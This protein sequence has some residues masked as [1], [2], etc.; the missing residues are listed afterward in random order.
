MS[1]LHLWRS[2][3]PSRTIRWKTNDTMRFMLLISYG[4]CFQGFLFSPQSFRKWSNVFFDICSKW[5]ER[6]QNH[7]WDIYKS[8]QICKVSSVA[9]VS[10]TPFFDRSNRDQHSLITDMC[11]PMVSFFFLFLLLLLV[12]VLVLVVPGR[13]WRSKLRQHAYWACWIWDPCHLLSEQLCQ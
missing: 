4:G 12:I 2:Y 9:L 5:I 10:I 6:C 7:R 11:F 13:T 8:K 3:Y 1:P